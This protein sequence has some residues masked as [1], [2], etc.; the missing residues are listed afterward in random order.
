MAHRSPRW[1]GATACQTRLLSN[2][3][4]VPARGATAWKARGSGRSPADSWIR[5]SPPS[6]SLQS[7]R[8]ASTVRRLVAPVDGS[9]SS[10]AYESLCSAYSA[11]SSGYTAT[12]VA[13]CTRR[14]SSPRGPRSSTRAG[15]P[16]SI[17]DSSHSAGA[18][19]RSACRPAPSSPNS[20][21]A[22]L[23]PRLHRFVVTVV[24]PASPSERHSRRQRA[25]RPASNA[26]GSRQKPWARSASRWAGLSSSSAQAWRQPAASWNVGVTTAPVASERGA[27]EARCRH[28]ARA[29]ARQDA[30]TLSFS[31]RSLAASSAGPASVA[32]A[33]S[34]A[35]PAGR[36]RSSASQ[37]SSTALQTRASFVPEI[38]SSRPSPPLSATARRSASSARRSR[39]SL[40]LRSSGP[41]LVRSTWRDCP[42]A[43]VSGS[44]IARMS[45]LYTSFGLS[46]SMKP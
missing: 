11:A 6:P 32:A 21:H 3:T 19:R 13:A 5:S 33:S 20:S 2:T 17:S 27:A 4:T 26:P 23:E 35:S 1:A 39:S 36:R 16:E 12:I 8:Y 43:A 46:F 45:M 29:K 9:M 10:G 41:L 34:R 18:S 24:A 28:I 31:A 37:A 25:A 15:S 7:L 30:S 42:V 38:S 22:E 40:M 44:R 14:A